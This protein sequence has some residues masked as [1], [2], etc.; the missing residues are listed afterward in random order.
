MKRNIVK[1]NFVSIFLWLYIL[2]MVL[3]CSKMDAY[4]EKFVPNGEVTYTGKIDSVKVFSGYNRVKFVAQLNSDPR[5]SYY[6]VYWGSR[7]DSVTFPVDANRKDKIIT[8][9][10]RGLVEGEYSFEFV[11]FD[12]DGNHSVPTFS[13]GTVYGNNFITNLINRKIVSSELTPNLETRITL[14]DVDVRSGI[15]ST[16]VRYLTNR[17]DSTSITIPNALNDTILKN[18]KYGTPI[19]ERSGYVPDSLSIDTLKALYTVYQPISGAAWINV[20]QKY[21]LNPGNSFLYGSWDGARWGILK[22]WISNDAVKNAKGYG[23]YELRGNNGVLSFEGGWGLPGITN[24]KI[25]QQIHLDR[26]GKWRFAVYVSDNGSV[27]TKYMFASAAAVIPDVE[28]VEKNALAYKNLSTV[29]VGTTNTIDI[30]IAAPM[31]I[32][33]GFVGNLPNTGSYMK[34]MYVTMSYY[35]Q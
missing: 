11:T 18:H 10:I 31:D 35:N 21:V 22:D 33:V 1:L 32:N 9:Y 12:S 34:V 13:N 28:N 27:G 26:A 8:Q 14:A 20:T 4:K 24:G 30:D 16:E 2:T 15:V 19:L 3:A 6:R 25:Y 17:G 5:V 7:K 29:G 23:G